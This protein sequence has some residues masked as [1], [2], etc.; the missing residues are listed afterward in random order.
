V[1]FGVLGYFAGKHVPGV[2]GFQQLK[3]SLDI[4]ETKALCA[5]IG[6]TGSSG[7]FVQ[8]SREKVETI[9]FTEKEFDDTFSELSQTGEGE[10][11]VFGCPQMTIEELYELSRLMGGK[12][13]RKKCF[14]F[15]SSKVYELAKSRGYSDVIE[16]SGGTFVRDACADFTPLISSL[17]VESVETDSCK[18]AHYMR[19]VHG[20]SIALKD[21]RR[22][23]EE[24]SK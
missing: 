7:M 21:T 17:N 19:K 12:H 24:N 13:L 15:C 16:A 3:P 22:I 9:D 8:N 5:S 11:I 2:I 10:A 6:T 1:D 4:S 20:V 23:I 14:V 18:G